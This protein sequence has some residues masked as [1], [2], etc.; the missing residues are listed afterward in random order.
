MAQDKASPSA[1]ESFKPYV[2]DATVIPEFTPR[3]VIL[4][5]V[6][7]VI[8]GAVTV[9][10]G[11]RAGLTVSA[12]IPIAVL[13]IS[14]L[15]ALGKATILENNIVQTTGSAGRVGGGGSDL[16]PARPR[17][18]GVPP[19]V[20][21]HLPPGHDRRRPGGPLHDPPAPPAHREGAR[22]PPLPRG[23]RLR[24]RARGRGE[25]RLLR[26]PGLLG[27][28]A[29]RRL[30]A[31]PE[32]Q[33]RRRDQGGSDLQPRVA[34]RGVD[35]GRHHLRVPGGGLHHRP[36]GGGHDLRGRGL[37]LARADAGHQVL[38]QP[39]AHADLPEPHPDRADDLGQPLELLHPLHRRGSGGGRRPDHAG[40]DPAHDRG[41]A[42]RGGG[43]DREEGRW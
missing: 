31:P 26:E 9:Y 10:V 18:P 35:A 30:H 5:M 2:P 43:G 37:L 4:G 28:R 23:H 19:P 7:G 29:R 36:A 22:Q 12:S 13:S 33:R 1:H 15:R 27:P 8:F 24:R 32:Q 21:P 39:R 41:R 14:L 40:Q 20:L 6:F 34:A 17:L 42:P 3:A 38:R 11:L 16:H 25:G